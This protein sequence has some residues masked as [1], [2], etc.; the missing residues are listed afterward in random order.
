MDRRY[1]YFMI[2]VV[3]I[4][5]THMGLRML[6]MPEQPAVKRED[7]KAVAEKNA[8][9]AKKDKEGKAKAGGSPAP[10]E[11][12]QD[13]GEKPAID[14]GGAKPAAVKPATG[15]PNKLI[16]LGSADESGGYALLVT[17]NNKGAAVER[18]EL[19]SPAY[20]DIEDASGYL[21]HLGLED[22]KGGIRISVVGA[23]TPASLAKESSGKVPGGLAADDMITSI[24]GTSA[25]DAAAVENYLTKKTKPGDTLEVKV[26][27]LIGGKS[28]PLTFTT[29]LT[30]RPVQVIRPEI[31]VHKDDKFPEHDPLSFLLTLESIAGKHVASGDEEIRG[32]PSIINRNW[33]VDEQTVDSVTFSLTLNDADLKGIGQTGSLKLIKRYKLA[34]TE[35]PEGKRNH[36]DLEIEIQ[37]A[38]KE[39]KE[40]AY[41]FSGPTGLPLEGWW[42][43]NKL[44]HDMWAGAGARDIAWKM[45]DGPHHLLGCPKIYSEAK[46]AQDKDDPAEQSLLI[47]DSHQ[48][49]DYVG[50]DTQ[51]F[52]AMLLPQLDGEAPVTFARAFAAPVQDLSRVEKKHI[53]TMDNTCVLV[54]PAKVLEPGKSLTTKFQ[55]FLGPKDQTVLQEYGLGTLIERGWSYA[56]YPASLLQLVLHGFFWLTGNYGI[57]IFLL[58]V[59]VRSC[60]LP[61]SLRQAKSAAKMQEL[62]P[63][64]AKLK[65]KYKD[66]MEKQSAALR[67]LYSK[68]NFNPFGGCLPV[69]LQLPIFVGLYRCLSVDIALRDA[70]L[71]PGFYWAS[72]LAGPDKLLF[73]K[74]WMPAMLADET[75]WLGPFLNVLPIITCGLFIVQ[76]K[77][78]TPPATDEQT[79]MQQ[80]MMSYMTI[81]M[82][83]MFFKV[84]A[85]LCIYF[86]TSSLWSIV[87]RKWIIKQKPVAKAAGGKSD[88]DS[89][90]SKPSTN[91]SGGNGSAKKIKK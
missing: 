40:L 29:T 20:R 63:E 77:L 7:E 79:A 9:K 15:P 34:G 47:G 41:R 88:D 83:V 4:L 67:E 51:F 61:L 69:F 55:V 90:P 59:L 62:A 26:T 57:S 58:T 6:F 30:R 19:A 65:E 68:H 70:D 76:Q 25:P 17:L 73:W 3:L 82:G 13:K 23:G 56:S 31:H 16:A 14:A 44:H 91:G 46:A 39:A 45:H 64:M 21:A 80:K 72:N 11:E 52:A 35:S 38:G 53:K 74:D 85:G 66:D 37:N 28:T 43:S 33:T 1:I 86:I 75:A 71:F 2:A 24:D 50:G 22:A 54:S 42:Y 27:R 49:L 32:L 84:P 10:G 12:K 89:R 5:G 60:M 18:A 8:D 78:F 36:L 48:A 87:E 81:F